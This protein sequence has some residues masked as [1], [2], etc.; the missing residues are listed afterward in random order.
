MGPGAELTKLFSAACVSC[1]SAAFRRF[2]SAVSSVLCFRL[3]GA[4]DTRPGGGG[5]EPQAEGGEGR[6]QRDDG[7]LTGTERVRQDSADIG[8]TVRHD[9]RMLKRTGLCVVCCCGR[10]ES[11]KKIVW[12]W[13]A[14]R[15]L[16]E[17]H[18]KTWISLEF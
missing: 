10:R 5:A 11:V 14:S 8:G 13:E 12:W 6:G 15:C 16:E 18:K 17:G 7:L 4:P 2:A 9:C 1:C 3:V